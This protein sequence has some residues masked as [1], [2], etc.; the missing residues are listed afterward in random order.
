M[1]KSGHVRA[2]AADKLIA[3]RNSRRRGSCAV[4]AARPNFLPSSG[5]V[6]ILHGATL[7]PRPPLSRHLSLPSRLAAAV[8][9]PEIRERMCGAAFE[10]NGRTET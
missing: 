8:R 9:V 7:L 4:S 3:F 5:A 1:L 2:P 10:N 6:M